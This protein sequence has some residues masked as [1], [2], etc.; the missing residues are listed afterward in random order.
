MLQWLPK[1]L[2]FFLL[3]GLQ[4]KSY[5]QDKLKWEGQLPSIASSQEKWIKFSQYLFEQKLYFGALAASYR[6]LLFFDD[7]ETSKFA[8]K[9]IVSLIDLGYP[10]N[11]NHFFIIGNIE[12]DEK[13]D[14]SQSYNFYKAIINK[15]KGMDKWSGD[16]FDKVDKEKFLKYR[17]Y[18][19]VNLYFEKKY[20]ESV[21][22]LDE[23]LKSDLP[24]KDFTFV[25]KVVRML[26]R[27]YFEQQK[28]E[29]S[30]ELYD[31]FLLKVNPLNPGDWIEKSWNLFYLKRYDDAIGILYN[32]DSYSMR[33]Y[34]GFEKYIIRASVYLNMCSTENVKKLIA[35]FN[36]DFKNPIQGIINGKELAKYP[37]LIKVAESSDPKYKEVMDSFNRINSEYKSHAKK[38]PSEFKEIAQYLYSTENKTLKQF[39][40][41]YK[42]RALSKAAE[43]LTMLSESLRFL[44]FGTEREKYNPA[45]VFIPREDKDEDLVKQIDLEN[46][47]FVFNWMQIGS[48][49]RDERNK[50]KA[51][52]VDRCKM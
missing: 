45:V 37:E 32:L 40:G 27:I 13:D 12:V 17:F 35:D 46:R 33:N 4:N 29:K 24:L 21:K 28:Y 43:D 39:S 48:F 11:L 42:E 47:G 18:Q 34:K 7:V 5:S 36:N 10:N 20:D 41:F 2:I 50:Y 30:L 3:I 1:F 23:I 51:T 49:W 8:Y 6:M 19:A 26:A 15:M 25:K 44:E 9:N 38:F 14:F 31:N 52:V 16:F 22:I